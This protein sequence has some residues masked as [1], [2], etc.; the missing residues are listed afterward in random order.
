MQ[1]YE[2]G[3]TPEEVITATLKV[4]SAIKKV[5]LA[6]KKLV[7]ATEKYLSHYKVITVSL[8]VI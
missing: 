6:T 7:S 4:I 2:R 8:K 1:I 5:I 3:I